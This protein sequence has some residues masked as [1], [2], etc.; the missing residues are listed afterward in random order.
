VPAKR[1]LP[2]TRAH[3]ITDAALMAFR[4]GRIV[5]LHRELGLRLWQVSPIEVDGPAA[6]ANAAP[7]DRE[8]W[9][10]AWELRQELEARCVG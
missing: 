4:G 2:K 5:A 1:R 8:S 9:A 10:L 6:P 3:R 7:G